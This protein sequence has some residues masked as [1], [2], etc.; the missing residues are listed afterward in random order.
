MN[1]CSLLL[2]AYSYA[3]FRRGS[4]Y[5]QQTSSCDYEKCLQVTRKYTLKANIIPLIYIFLLIVADSAPARQ[6]RSILQMGFITSLKPYS[7]L[8]GIFGPS[9]VNADN[10]FA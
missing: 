8:S 7:L 9:L 4:I 10:S 3:I 6:K 2:Y 5:D 1:L